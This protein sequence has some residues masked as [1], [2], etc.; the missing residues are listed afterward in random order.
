[1]LGQDVFSMGRSVLSDWFEDSGQGFYTIPDSATLLLVKLSGGGGGGG[2]AI[3]CNWN[4]KYLAGG[5]GG[6]A[7]AAAVLLIDLDS[8]YGPNIPYSIGQGGV[9]CNS[10]RLFNTTQSPA[11]GSFVTSNGPYDSGGDTSFGEFITCKGGSPG[12]SAWVDRIVSSPDSAVRDWR[13]G[14]SDSNSYPDF[15]P[16]SRYPSRLLKENNPWDSDI[17]RGLGTIIPSLI[18]SY[19]NLILHIRP[20]LGYAA[21]GAG[22]DTGPV[23][24]SYYYLNHP[25]WSAIGGEA[26]GIVVSKAGLSQALASEYFV[27]GGGGGSTIF[28]FGGNGG[29]S[30]GAHVD[31]ADFNGQDAYLG[32]G[33]G[34]GGAASHSTSVFIFGGKGLHGKGGSGAKGFI[35]VRA[36]K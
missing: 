1:M 10:L 8:N 17:Y 16:T 29:S 9:G 6:Q 18:D 5:Q 28:G 35:S 27:S 4:F 22:G 34:G 30:E 11:N 7:G 13:G 31:S 3:A 15:A 36:F 24:G 2:G 21:G 14:A 12:Q 33:G 32:Y 23:T 26:A 25:A 19:N 20:D